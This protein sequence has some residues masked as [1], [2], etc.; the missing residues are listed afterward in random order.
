M[1]FHGFLCEV[2]NPKELVELS[3][4]VRD[5]GYT[6]FDTYSPFPIHGIDKAMGIPASVL[7]WLSL[8]GCLIGL[9]S[10]IILQVWTSGIDYKIALSGKPYAALPAF[11][12]VTFELTILFTAFFTVFG[13]FGLNKLPT[14]NKPIFN[15][16]SIKRATCSGF[17]LSI[18]SKD[19]NFDEEKTM[20][21]LKK[22]G[23]NNIERIQE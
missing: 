6:N 17:F 16:E 4:K 23:G 3:K 13:M 15:N 8:T 20:Q 21:F 22:S 7:P 5:S 10:A 2:E 14:W 11:V 19:K 1:V 12:P 18:S 9:T